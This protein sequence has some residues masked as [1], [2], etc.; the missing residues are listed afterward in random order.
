MNL[1]EFEQQFYP[2]RPAYSI[3]QH[4]DLIEENLTLA[5]SCFSAWFNKESLM[6]LYLEM[7]FVGVNPFS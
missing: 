1:M 3:Y 5:E 2:R 4:S 7:I 6:L